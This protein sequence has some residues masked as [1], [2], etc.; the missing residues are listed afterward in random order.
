MLRLR[1]EDH[2]KDEEIYIHFM[3][4]E[5][6]CSSLTGLSVV[7]SQLHR[8]PGIAFEE[9][10]HTSGDSPR[11]SYYPDRGTWLEVQSTRTT[12]L[13]LQIAVV[14]VVNFP[15]YTAACHGLWFRCGDPPFYDMDEI[16]VAD[17]Q[18]RLRI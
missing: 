14:V 18:A 4:S 9:S 12:F 6:A 8:S 7:V 5:R 11:L 10:V 1:E 3:V 13:C 15:Y 2:I 16:T 17:A